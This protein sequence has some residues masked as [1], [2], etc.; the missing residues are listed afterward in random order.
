[1]DAQAEGKSWQVTGK[2]RSAPKE[3]DRAEIKA[4]QW[5]VTLCRRQIGRDGCIPQETDAG[6]VGRKGTQLEFDNAGNNV[7]ESANIIATGPNLTLARVV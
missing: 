5:P 6:V 4:G 1:V 7:K 3:R 2:T